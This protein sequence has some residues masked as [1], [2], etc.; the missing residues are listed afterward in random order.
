MSIALNILF[1]KN[2]EGEI[3]QTYLFKHNFSGENKVVLLI[4][5]DE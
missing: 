3:N 1:L 5:T 2:D 4:I